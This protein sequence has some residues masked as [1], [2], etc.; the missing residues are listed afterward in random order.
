MCSVL[1]RL[2]AGLLPFIDVRGKVVRSSGAKGEMEYW[3]HKCLCSLLKVN[4]IWGSDKR[5]PLLLV[6]CSWV[7][8]MKEVVKS[9]VHTRQLETQGSFGRATFFTVIQLSFFIISI[10]A[11]LTVTN[12]VIHRRVTSREFNP[13]VITAR[14]H[15]N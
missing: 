13:P 12:P 7:T 11:L 9:C 1:S 6:D 10:I 4:S 5:V 15:S 3:S 8:V 14:S 2:L